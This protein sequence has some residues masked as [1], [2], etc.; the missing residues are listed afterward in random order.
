MQTRSITRRFRATVCAASVLAGATTALLG[1]QD[2]SPLPGPSNS[3][4]A[5][6]WREAPEYVALF[7][8]PLYRHAYQAFVSTLRL[9]RAVQ[10]VTGEEAA[11]A[12]AAPGSWQARLEHPLDAFGSGGT[13]DRW[14]VL[15][16]YGSQR[17][18]VAR[19]PRGTAGIV[20]QSWTLISPFPSADL[21]TLDSGT[22]LIVLRVS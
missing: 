4:P 5:A 9:D 18:T 22:L 11:R 12:V 2:L 17:P 3:A 14:A 15:R 21:A 1:A 20:D 10:L 7:A 8:P 19:G 13:Y 16:L 6:V